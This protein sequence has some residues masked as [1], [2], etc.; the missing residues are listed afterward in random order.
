MTYAGVLRLSILAALLVITAGVVQAQTFS[1]LYDFGINSGDPL[2]PYLEGI[3]AQGRDGNL[4]S[5]A[6]NG[7]T[8]G[9]GAVFK[10]TPEGALTTLCSFSGGSDGANPQGGMTMGSD[11]NFYGT[12][13]T[14]GASN[15]GTIFK[16]T[17]AGKFTLLYSFTSN[18]G[19]QAC[20][21]PIQGTDGNFYGTAYSGG[22][23]GDG[24]VY[25]LASSGNF[26]TL[27]SFDGTHGYNPA[28]P[29]IQ[30]LMAT[31]MEPRR[32]AAAA[33]E[34]RSSGSHPAAS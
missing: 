9:Y 2:H 31:S 10:I 30:G 21:P 25:K 29:L 27:Y 23:F 20:D 14:S 3:V 18:D 12:T 34:A 7:G 19:N 24:M 22:A 15:R 33:E 11:G 26:T 17:P 1:V 16:I 4:Y 6:P 28:A 5:A 13:F 32:A 8:N